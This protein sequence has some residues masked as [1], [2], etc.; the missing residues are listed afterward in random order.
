MDY[1]IK[2]NYQSSP[3]L[4]YNENQLTTQQTNNQIKPIMKYANHIVNDHIRLTTNQLKLQQQ[5]LGILV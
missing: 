4:S 2:F 3:F 5:A 1:S